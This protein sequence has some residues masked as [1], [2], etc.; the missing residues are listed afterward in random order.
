MHIKTRKPTGNSKLVTTDS[1][2]AGGFLYVCL[3]V[4]EKWSYFVK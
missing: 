2:R 3:P 1:S 4:L